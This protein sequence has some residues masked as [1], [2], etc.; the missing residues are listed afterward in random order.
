M[1]ENKNKK[2]R[3][4][5]QMNPYF[6]TRHNPNWKVLLDTIGESD[7]NIADLIYEVR[8]QFF[9]NTSSRPYI[10]RLASNLNVSRPKIV[11][12]DDT[13]MRRYVP[14]LAYQPKQVKLIMDQL[15]DVFFFREAT[16]AF[17]ETTV[18]EPYFIKDGWELEYKVDID[19]NEKISFPAVDFTDETQAKAEEI[20]SILNRQAKYSFAIVFDNRIEKKK[21]IRIFTKTVGSKGSIEISGGRANISLKSH[22]LIEGAGSL[23]TTVWNIQ[24]VGDTTTFTYTSGDSPNLNLVQVGDIAIIDIPGNSGSFMVQ[25]VDLFAG[26]FSFENLFS[27]QGLFSHLDNPGYYVRFFR[28]ERSV[29]YT[30]NNRSAVWEVSSGEIII[31]MPATPPVVRR[32]LKGSAHING[33]SK[34]MVKVNSETSI[35]IEDASEWPDSGQFAIEPTEEI[36]THMVT[37]IE[38]YISTQ[39]ILGRFDIAGRRHSYMSKVGNTLNGINPP[40]PQVSGVYE[41]DI[42]C[43]SRDIDGIVTVDLVNPF[44][45]NNEYICVYNTGRISLDGTFEIIEVISPTRF[46]YMNI[47]PVETVNTGKIRVERIGLKNSGSI[48]HLTSSRVNTGVFGPTL[49]DMRAPFILSSYTCK[50]ETDIK[51]GNIVLNLQVTAPNSIP[52]ERGFLIFDYGLETQEGP[53]RYMYK[54]SDSVIAIDPSYVFQFDHGLGSTVTAIRRKGAHVMSGKG[55]EYAF[56]TSDPSAARKVLQELIKEVKSV[57]TFLKFIVR[58][59][60]NYYSEFDLY[61]ATDDPLD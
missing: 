20:V 50:S 33:L 32:G 3:L 4:H 19:K 38:D 55:N 11:G 57:G 2:D 31:E 46:K 5:E 37:P 25:N 44:T 45:I 56:Y 52:N 42:A 61:A 54:A 17:L 18:P 58:Y 30:R 60:V 53:V 26:S 28:P 41:L 48:V 8:K 29:V 49:W 13:T 51:A 27:T 39:T 43:I 35:D 1:A 59:P 14:I 6:N 47:G 24:K 12:M 36:Q 21:Y 16:T 23:N 15:L 40:I 10:D 34:T 22:G 7:Q 9:I